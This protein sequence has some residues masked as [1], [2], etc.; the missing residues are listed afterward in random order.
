MTTADITSRRVPTGLGH[1]AVTVRTG[2]PERLPLVLGH[3]VFYDSDLWTP[4]LAH[5]GDRTVVTVD[6]P[7]HG[8]SDR[9]RRGWTLGDH[10]EALREVLDALGLDVSVVGGH[11]WGGMVALRLALAHPSRTAGLA[12]VNTPLLATRGATRFGFRAQQAIL[13]TTGSSAFYARQAAKAVNDAASLA[14]HPEV[15]D[16]FVARLTAQRG[17][18]LADTLRAITLEPGDQIEALSGLA[19]PVAVVGGETDY[20]FTP[21]VRDAVARA[22]PG[23]V[24]TTAT[25]G[26]TSPV[27]DPDTV[28]DALRHLLDRAEAARTDGRTGEGSAPVSGRRG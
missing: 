21:G 14:A 26:H 7:G 19:V 15:T 9:P 12:L 1:L 3:G 24:L 27:A 8:G 13:R 11:S 17:A 6:G 23:A 4:V 2:D 20:A 5:L 28:A 18:D 10:V 16:G 22:L 25:G